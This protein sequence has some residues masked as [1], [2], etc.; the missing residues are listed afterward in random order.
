[1]SDHDDNLSYEGTPIASY[2]VVDLRSILD[3]HGLSK[4]GTKKELAARL[5]SF[6]MSQD[7]SCRDSV[8]ESIGITEPE[9][10]SGLQ[11]DTGHDSTDDGPTPGME[12]RRSRRGEI[13][14]DDPME[15]DS[16]R[17]RS[18]RRRG[19][20]EEE[21]DTPEKAN[22]PL[23]PKLSLKGRFSVSSPAQ[24]P[25]AILS[26]ATE[27]SDE[28]DDDDSNSSSKRKHKHKKRREKEHDDDISKEEKR[29]R[30]EKRREEKERKRRERDSSGHSSGRE[31]SGQRIDEK[32]NPP[33]G[34][35]PASNDIE[36]QPIVEPVIMPKTYPSLEKDKSA[37]LS[38][39]KKDLA[40]SSGSTDSAEATEKAAKVV[41]T[42]DPVEVISL[43]KEKVP[44]LELPTSKIEVASVQSTKETLE[45]PGESVATAAAVKAP[46]PKE[47]DTHSSAVI[48]KPSK[49]EADVKK[50]KEPVLEESIE[51]VEKSDASRTEEVESSKV[52]KPEGTKEPAK[53]EESSEKS[54][55]DSSKERR[56]KTK[57]GASII[58]KMPERRAEE[59]RK[60]KLKR[61]S[62]SRSSVR[63]VS[64]DSH[65]T[66]R[67]HEEHRK[68]IAPR[69]SDDDKKIVEHG[70]QERADEDSTTS[71]K[72]EEK[73]RSHH[74]IERRKLE[75]KRASPPKLRKEER[76]RIS[77]P[78]KS[79]PKERAKSP[80]RLSKSDEPTSNPEVSAS[81]ETETVSQVADA[82]KPK[83]ARRKLQLKRK[84]PATEEDSVDKEEAQDNSQDH[85]KKRRGWGSSGIT[86]RKGSFEISMN[87]LR[88]LVSPE[89]AKEEE[90]EDKQ[91]EEVHHEEATSPRKRRARKE[92]EEE[93]EEEKSGDESDEEVSRTRKVRKVST[94]AKSVDEQGDEEMDERG[95]KVTS[96]ELKL[97]ISADHDVEAPRRVTVKNDITDSG[98]PPRGPRAVTPARN[99]PNRVIHIKN[100]M[101]PYT[102][103]QLKELLCRTGSLE[104]GLFWTDKIKSQCIACYETEEQAIET[105][106]ALHGVK[107][108][109]SN[110]KVLRVDFSSEEELKEHLLKDEEEQLAA[111]ARAVRSGGGDE[112]GGADGEFGKENDRERDRKRSP[113]RFDSTERKRRSRSADGGRMRRIDDRRRSSRSPD[114][115]LREWDRA[116]MGERSPGAKER[117]RE[118][119]RRERIRE[120][121]VARAR[122]DDRRDREKAKSPAKLLDD[123]FRKTKTTPCI[124]WLPLTEEQIAQK[125]EERRQRVLE[126]QRRI[127]EMEKLDK[128]RR[129]GSRSRS[130]SRSPGRNRFRGGRARR[131]P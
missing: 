120:E 4:T 41:P 36:E 108:P 97:K 80:E 98:I 25:E 46:T 90:D 24:E 131:Y 33:N 60:I 6:V 21:D 35:K 83:P 57:E 65:R 43:V 70:K 79:P 19:A 23:V 94:T 27:E 122:M 102:I 82:S 91:E 111:S 32:L 104:P 117:E 126:R 10:T 115:S 37:T 114:A 13:G 129:R 15:V 128:E 61:S 116:K 109:V 85:G 50:T 2:R 72:D 75:V 1:M 31:E 103:N 71:K 76:T 48:V 7:G 74:R 73:E 26:T 29:E 51:K 77:P 113:L 130:L 64:E 88:T 53:S 42:E 89:P 8:E 84:A 118:N 107:W 34:E 14:L 112:H 62:E 69:A 22:T 49:V 55:D 17:R 93:A 11:S 9:P 101:R 38:D 119:R 95:A 110:N 125:E 52:V 96:R 86:T 12:R 58:V 30:K 59:S 92:E 47:I 44:D 56:Y 66:P 68:P 87:T 124:Y 123:L 20:D 5:S 3:K 81:A 100:L 18:S 16:P 39:S 63:D 54:S 121:E 105:R 28:D 99:P 127:T 40:T 45:S 78:K 67:S 106:L